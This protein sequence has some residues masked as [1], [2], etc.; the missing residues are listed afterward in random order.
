MKN[1][2]ITLD[3]L[4]RLRL[5]RFTLSIDDFGTGHSTLAQL[6]D[7]PFDEFKIDRSFVHRAWVDQRIKAMFENSLNLAKQLGMSV[8]AEGVETINDWNFLRKTTCDFAQG[9]FIAEP[10]PGDELPN[11]LNAWQKQVRTELIPEQAADTLPEKASAPSSAPTAL[12][13]EDHEF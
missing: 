11:W 3:T 9:Y 12:I 7:I 10:M 4:T 1:P 2:A 6:R 5:K 13:I 8:V